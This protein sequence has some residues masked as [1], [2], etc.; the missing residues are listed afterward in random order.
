MAIK[1][2]S[3]VYPNKFTGGIACL[4]VHVL[5]SHLNKYPDV[6]SRVYFID[7]ITSYSIHYTKLYEKKLQLKK[8]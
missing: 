1:N 5:T 8:I 4:A 6:N 7:V 3:I 2:V